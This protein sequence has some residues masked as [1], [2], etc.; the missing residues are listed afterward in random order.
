MLLV[1]MSM[2]GFALWSI[3]QASRTPVLVAGTAIDAGDTIERSDLVV[4]SVGADAGLEL[5][6][7]GREELVVGRVA[8]GPIP[9][10]TPLSTALVVSATDAVP[11][12]WAVVGAALEPGEYPSSSIQAGDRVLLVRTAPTPSAADGGVTEIGE[13]VIWTVEPFPNS[14]RGE[15]FVSLLVRQVEAPEVSNVAAEARLRLLLLGATS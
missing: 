12:G 13:A 2:L 5:L 4:V 3:R 7:S 11:A 1:V 6:E 10:G 9:A 8:R 15:L 14:G